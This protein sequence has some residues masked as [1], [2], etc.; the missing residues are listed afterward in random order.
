MTSRLAT[1]MQVSERPSATRDHASSPLGMDVDSSN[2]EWDS[3]SETVFAKSGELLVSFC[4]DLPMEIK[5]VLKNTGKDNSKPVRLLDG[6]LFA[7]FL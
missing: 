7:R 2:S 4:A 1:P 5:Q 6:N 3:R